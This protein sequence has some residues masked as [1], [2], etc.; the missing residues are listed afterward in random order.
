MKQV[1]SPT[2][3]FETQAPTLREKYLKV[4]SLARANDV[5]EAPYRK[6][7]IAHEREVARLH[8]KI[9]G[10]E[11]TFRQ[12]N[13]R[14]SR[15]HMRKENLLT[16]KVTIGNEIARLKKD[17]A[18]IYSSKSYKVGWPLRATI[19]RL[20]R[21]FIVLRE[22]MLP[23]IEK[24]TAKA[25]LPKLTPPAEWPRVDVITVSYNSAA[26]VRP[27][28]SALRRLDY[29]REKLHFFFVD[30]ASHDG[31]G[32]LLAHLSKDL[33]RS[34]IQ[35]R[36]NGGFTAGNN[37]ALRTSL[38][39]YIL[40]LNPDTEIA[41]DCLKTLV[42]RAE[43]ERG[44]GLVEPA[45]QPTEHPKQY[46]LITQETSW[47]SGASSLILRSALQ[48]TGVFDQTFFMY[49]EDVDISWRMWSKGYRCIYEPRAKFSHRQDFKQHKGGYRAYY[50][51]FRNGLMMRFIF[52]GLGPYLHYAGKM[53]RIIFFQDDHPLQ[54]KKYLLK[55]LVS[56]LRHMPHLILRRREQSTVPPN[57]RVRFYGWDYSVRRW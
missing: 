13:R 44:V 32:R 48:R 55:A 25:Q 36:I 46:D 43:A 9:R 50:L 11:H 39:K 3:F 15:T 5:R 6:A 1:A 4:S 21:P 40:L 23:A 56:H 20:K 30:N 2:T 29:P 35:S 31:S 8:K 38:A 22:S 7:V 34:F 42:M 17:L 18:Q 24:P 37:I 27:F 52:G 12:A 14:L 19:R 28:L 54:A 45:Q 10:L 51:A 49:C 57:E 53:L 41:R 16:G 47:C 26:H 33:P